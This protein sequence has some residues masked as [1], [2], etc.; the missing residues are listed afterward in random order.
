VITCTT[1]NVDPGPSSNLPFLRQT[2]RDCL[3]PSPIRTTV[4]DSSLA[5]MVCPT[6][7]AV[8]QDWLSM[9]RIGCVN[10]PIK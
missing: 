4:L 8:L 7:T 6:G 3:V 9:P 10:G 2:A 5:V 1:W